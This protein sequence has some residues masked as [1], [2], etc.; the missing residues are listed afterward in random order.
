MT[1][2]KRKFSMLN[3]SSTA[4][5][6]ATADDRS[7]AARIRDAAIE[8]FAEA[9]VDATSVRAI[10]ARAGVSAALVIHHFGSK[11]QLRVACDEHV[12]ASVRVQKAAAMRQGPGMD[13]L[14]A[15]RARDAAPPL[16]AYLARTLT[17]GSPHVDE[18]LD[19]LVDDAA[20]YLQDGIDNGVLRPV[21]DVRGLAAL[22]TVWSL[23][24]VVL[25]DHTRRLLGA[26]LLAGGAA[27]IPYLAP[28]L[29][30]FA[31]GILT[32][33]AGRSMRAQLRQA[34]DPAQ[35]TDPE[36][37]SATDPEPGI[38]SGDDLTTDG[39]RR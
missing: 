5:G 30:L 21:E 11:E 25:H 27:A 39:G 18:L 15:L 35:A 13:V 7:T 38:D 19:E 26:D 3:M 37:A 8:A 31:G 2:I 22:L 17:D 28:A 9:G 14:A 6:S 12:A 33:A 16:L 29:E 24:A 23:G 1:G 32:D 10:A 4:A 34:T 36:P 20:G